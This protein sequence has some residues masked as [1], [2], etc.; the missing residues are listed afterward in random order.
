MTLAISTPHNAARLEGTRAFADTGAANS[1]I[2][3][4][5]TTQPAVGD[6]P[7]GTPVAT[8]ILAKPC[9]L[10]SGSQMGLH[11]NDLSGDLIDVT[12]TVLW[13]RWVNGDGALVADGTVSDNAGTGD[14]KLSGTAGTLLYA[15]GRV[16]L[17]V[18]NIG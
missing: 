16:L 14:L 2:A 17:G 7:G 10:V 9:G 6:P 12:G 18:C 11:Q 1:Q 5:A 15:G 13:A 8:I 3:L 4:Y